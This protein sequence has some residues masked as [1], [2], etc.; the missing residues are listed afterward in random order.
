MDLSKSELRKQ[1]KA[2]REAVENKQRLALQAR[3]QFLKEIQIQPSE[4]VAFYWPH[5]NEFPINPILDE[6]LGQGRKCAFPVMDDG[7][8][9]LKF[10]IWKSGDPLREGKYKIKE[11]MVTDPGQ[12]VDPDIVIV[13]LIAFDENGHRLGYGGGYYDATLQDLR[14]RK[15]VLAIGIAF[16]EQFSDVPFSQEGHDQPIDLVITPEN[17]YRFEK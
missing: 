6:L 11:P 3:E 17:V 9:I 10:A 8:R 5:Q 1:F 2:V 15:N 12:Y 16:Q 13:P 7:T 4:V 14:S